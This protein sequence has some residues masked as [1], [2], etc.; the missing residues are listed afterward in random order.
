LT[1]ALAR[2]AIDAASMAALNAATIGL[3]VPADFFELLAI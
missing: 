3:F 2:G 1:E